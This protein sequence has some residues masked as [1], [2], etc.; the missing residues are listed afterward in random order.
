[1]IVS[2][3]VLAAAANPAPSPRVACA[4]NAKPLAIRAEKILLGNGKT[5]DRGVILVDQGRIAAVGQDLDIPEGAHVVN[6]H[7]TASAGLVALH[8][9]SGNPS[10]LF[11]STRTSMPEAR[12]AHAFDPGDQDLAD[13][14][15]VGI[16][17]LVVA[18][19][20]ASICSGTSALVKTAGGTVVREE[21]QLSLGFSA[22]SLRNNRFPTS[23]GGALAEL[24]RSFESPVG[25]FARASSGKLPVLLEVSDRQ[26]VARA[27][28][29]AKRHD[30]VGAVSG[31]AWAG[32]L[33]DRIRAAKLGVVCA[34]VRIGEER[35]DL[36]AVLALEKAGVPFG[37]AIDTPSN[38]PIVLR[39]GAAMCVREG[40]DRAAAWR[41]LTSDAARIAGAEDRIGSLTKGLDADIVLWSGDPL[42]L[43]SR[44]EAVYVDGQ[45]A[46]KEKP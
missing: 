14:L 22:R 27:V 8:S 5:I 12:V 20:P 1:M 37:F 38:H 16:T 13:A 24:D 9:Y 6:H 41:A 30:L 39:T 43:A 42:D 46:W 10:E 36:L 4:P 32:E 11:D 44:A 45:L 29:F 25:A 19:I 33:A 17:S 28:E 34:P 21:A 40:L 3:L 35:R 15:R 23:F 26:D 2:M 18:P 31:A 7:G